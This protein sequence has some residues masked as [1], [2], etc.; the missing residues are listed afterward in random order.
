MSV[1]PVIGHAERRGKSIILT[2]AAGNRRVYHKIRPGSPEHVAATKH[3]AE[4]SLGRKAFNFARAKAKHLRSGLRKATDDQVAGRFVI[5]QP[6]PLYKAI[7]AKR[8]ICTH[9]NCGCDSKA[10]GVAGKNKL[11]D[12]SSSCPIE[13]WGPIDA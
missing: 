12:A 7:S 4:P 10:P 6:C 11:R 1:E 2:D 3:L 8:G 13:R 9:Q 5:C